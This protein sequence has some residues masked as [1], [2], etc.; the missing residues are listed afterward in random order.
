MF[1]RHKVCYLMKLY[2]QEEVKVS[3]SL[4]LMRCLQWENTQVICHRVELDLQN[5]T[6][7]QVKLVSQILILSHNSKR[8]ELNGANLNQALG[9]LQE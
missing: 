6:I 5:L 2:L 1:T 4:T 7:L 3:M 8:K 9:H